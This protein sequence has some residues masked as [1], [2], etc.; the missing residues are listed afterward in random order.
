MKALIV[1]GMLVAVGPVAALQRPAPQA[2]FRRR[3]D[4]VQL[5]V[6][7]VRRGQPVRGLTAADFVVT[8]NGEPQVVDSVVLDQLPLNVELVLDTSGSVVGGRLKHLIAAA[9]SLLTALRPG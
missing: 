1:A 9:D 8:D 5:D 3:V 4:V 2:T 6:S 7:V